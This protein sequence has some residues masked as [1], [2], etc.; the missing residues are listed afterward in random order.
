MVEEAGLSTGEG[1][2]KVKSLLAN[3]V[4]DAE[5]VLEISSNNPFFTVFNYILQPHLGSLT[6]NNHFPILF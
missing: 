2:D 1:S 5:M 6:N 3:K 4:G